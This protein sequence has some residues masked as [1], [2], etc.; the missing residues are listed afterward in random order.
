MKTREL[1]LKASFDAGTCHISSALSC[2]EIVESIYEKMKDRDVFL[3]SKASGAATLY[4]VLAQRGYFPL[5]KLAYYLKN[6]PLA[7]KEVSGVL[8]SVGSLGQGLSVACGLALSDRARNVYCLISDAE[9]CEGNTWEA[10]L[11]AAQHE[12]NN[13]ITI[14]DY[15]RIYAC[16]R[17]ED[18][19]GLE[20]LKLKLKAFNWHVTSLDGHDNKQLSWALNKPNLHGPY[21]IIAET[22]KGKGV[23]FMENSVE[24]HYR[25]LSESQLNKALK[26][27]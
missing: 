15:N 5:E 14:V 18:V 10:I 19:L 25:N 1:I 13:L 17:S 6:F 22:I 3:F 4:A 2:V 9:L 12:L 23:N 24:W 20:P 11:F 27:L 21:I 16:G 8:H 26:Q 7:S